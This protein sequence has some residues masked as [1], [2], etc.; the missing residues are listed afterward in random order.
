LIKQKDNRILELEKQIN[1]MH[2]KENNTET[3][4]ITNFSEKKQD[5]P[6]QTVI[7]EKS[8]LEPEFKIKI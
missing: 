5:K 3:I 7:K 8:K 6:V 4:N 2:K 1:D